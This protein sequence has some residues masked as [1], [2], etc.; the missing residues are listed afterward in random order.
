MNQGVGCDECSCRGVGAAAQEKALTAMG[1]V[2][3]KGMGFE[4][5]KVNEMADGLA[6][7][8]SDLNSA[9]KVYGQL[10]AVEVGLD[11]MEGPLSALSRATGNRINFNA[12]AKGATTATVLANA[13]KAGGPF[14][15]PGQAGSPAGTGGSPG[16]DGDTPMGVLPAAGY[17]AGALGVAKGVDVLRSKQAAKAAAEVAE[18]SAPKLFR[19]L[20]MV[21]GRYVPPGSLAAP[22]LDDVASGAASSGGGLL[23]TTGK[24]IG[25]VLS[26]GF[27]YKEAEESIAAGKDST[28]AF[29]REGLGAAGGILR[30]LWLRRL[31]IWCACWSEV[32]RQQR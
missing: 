31:Q 5:G 29:T 11:L 27:A 19:G 25:P 28:E 3:L 6:N 20:P 22:V 32:L 26:L 13:G 17:T 12:L 7:T 8:F 10:T 14:G 21:P 9:A 15:M 16:P 1:D 18:A 24:V 2:E 4:F 23:K 30:R